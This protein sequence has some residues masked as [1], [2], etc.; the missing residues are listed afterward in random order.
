MKYCFATIF[1]LLCLGCGPDPSFTEECIPRTVSLPT[2]TVTLCE[3]EGI[4]VDPGQLYVAM[5]ALIKEFPIAGEYVVYIPYEIIVTKNDFSCLDPD[6]PDKV[7]TG[8]YWTGK[9]KIQYQHNKC[10]GN[11]SFIH[12]L[13]HSVLY[14]STGDP[15][16]DHTAIE[17]WSWVYGTIER[18]KS[19][20]RSWCWNNL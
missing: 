10:I 11:T 4:R 8:L 13:V 15:D 6:N 12:E 17:H 7:C 2:S 1:L 16:G 18:A 5:Q 9:D 20:V 19:T 3:T 14:E